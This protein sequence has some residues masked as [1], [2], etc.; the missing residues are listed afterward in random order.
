MF[1][2]NVFLSKILILLLSSCCLKSISPDLSVLENAL[3]KCFHVLP[4]FCICG[5]TSSL[6]LNEAVNVDFTQ[7]ISFI[8]NS[9]QLLSLGTD[10]FYLKGILFVIHCTMLERGA[11][12][13]SLSLMMLLL[14]SSASYQNEMVVTQKLCTLT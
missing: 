2:V 13:V 12:E 5:F 14:F 11:R 4:Y 6:P 9:L 10:N 7:N 1:E 3:T 8:H